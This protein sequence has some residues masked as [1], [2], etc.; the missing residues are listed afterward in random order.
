MAPKRILIYLFISV[1]ALHADWSVSPITLDVPSPNASSPAS[2]VV[3]AVGNVTAAW[4]ENTSEETSV[5]ASYY[6]INSGTWTVPAT[7]DLY[8]AA[9]P[10][11]L[12]VDLAGNVT[13][14]WLEYLGGYVVQAARFDGISWTPPATLDNG[15]QSPSASYN[16]SPQ[17]VVDAQ[18]NVTVVWIEQLESTY[19]VQAARFSNGAWTTSP[20]TLDGLTPNA[21]AN[22]N[23]Q[24]VVDATGNVTVVWIEQQDS[25]NAVQAARFSG[26]VWTTVPTTLDGLSPNANVTPPV[27]IVDPLGNVTVTWLEYLESSVGVEAARFSDGTWTPAIFLDNGIQ[28]PNASSAA[29][30]VVDASGNVTAA[31]LENTDV[32]TMVQSSYYAINSGT[33][34]SPS[35]IDLYAAATQPQLIMDR[36][37]IVTAAWLEYIGGYVVQAARFNGSTWTAP[38]TLDNGTQLPNAYLPFS[39]RMVIDADGNVTVTWF[40]QQGDNLAVQ[41]A[42]FSDGSWTSSPATLDGSMPNANSNT[43]ILSVVDQVGDVT[44]TWIENVNNALA[45]EAA[46]FSGNSW[47]SAAV[48]NNGAQIP[49]AYSTPGLA[50]IVDSLGDVT[51]TWVENS[52]NPT[53]VQVTRYMITLFP[54]ANL[55]GNQLINQFLSQSEYF[56][57]LQWNVPSL[58]E[59]PV[60]YRIYR[61]A[62]LT[63]LAGIVDYTGNPQLEF[64]DHNR[65]PGISY[66]YYI[67]S[68]DSG[69]NVSAPASIVVP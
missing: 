47:A 26:N 56:N 36:L 15:T 35:T 6:S 14:V 13:A 1:S 31:W 27:M 63:D 8:A 69:G 53:A 5:E 39:P 4:L 19:A 22:I 17:M 51:V 42:R 21:N 29:S 68:V 44:V 55:T 60:A 41:A 30:L 49:D 58:G 33:W 11:Q 12:V 25:A 64:V 54:P 52:T 67:V 32:E 20:T 34:T 48:L 40:E 59:V 65:T 3:D 16:N 10:P 18:G 9:A 61:D 38:T 45:V 37:G 23:P 50:L 62:S 7:I 43:P 24:I 46:R 28:T 2:L 57:V 66:T